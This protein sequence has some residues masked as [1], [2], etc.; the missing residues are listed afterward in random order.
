MILRLLPPLLLVLCGAAHAD[1]AGLCP[2]TDDQENCVRIIACLGD[3]G[4][5]FQGRAFGRGMGALAG[6]FN[7]GTSC[8]G[9]WTNS[10]AAGVPQADFSCDDGMTVSVLYL[11]QDAYTGT[12]KGRG[13]TNHGDLVEAWSGAHVLELFRDGDPTAEAILQCGN[14]G[15]PLS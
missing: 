7:D 3:Q 14:Y 4:K 15:I 1:E 8:T 12:A 13:I 10:N 5:W 9:R 2:L 6:V 11:H